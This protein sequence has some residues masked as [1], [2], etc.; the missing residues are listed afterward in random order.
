MLMLKSIL[1]VAFLSLPITVI[2]QTK[3]INFEH[4]T[5]AEIKT[6]AKKENKLIFVDAF[7]TWCGPCKQMSNN[8]F[9][10]DTVAD[11]FNKNFV[12]AKIDMEKDEGIDLAKQYEVKCYPNLLFIDGDGNVIHRVAGSMTA[13]EFIV[14]AEDTKKPQ[15]CY[16]Y[17]SK[18]YEANKNKSDFLR[19]YIDAREG[20]CLDVDVLLKR[21]FDMQKNDD[22]LSKENWLMIKNYTNNIESREFKYIISNKVKFENLYKVNEVNEKLNDVCKS[23]LFNVLR[24]LPVDEKQ[25]TELK[26][27][28]TSLNLPGTKQNLF[29]S[30]LYYHEVK[31][32]WDAYAKL[33]C[34]NVDLYYSKDAGMLNNIAWSFYEHVSNMEYL[35]KAES[36]AKTAAELDDSYANLDTYASILFKT[37]KKEASLEVAKK[38]IVAA[39]KQN[40]LPEDYETTS[41]LILKI[42]G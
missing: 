23:S 42:K 33:A 21:Y 41:N 18:N 11:Y 22:L 10:N 29:D 31:N 36:W 27:K 35:Y 13:H 28:V 40:M 39:K 17:Y 8:V 26:S 12:N 16:S 14:F 32:E 2:S 19:N 1:S 15:K 30:D 37:G 34:Y 25:Y 20:T 9:T 5:F 24:K 4:G 38:A 3:N 7:T 6:K